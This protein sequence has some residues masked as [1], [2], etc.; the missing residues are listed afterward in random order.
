MVNE[1]ALTAITRIDLSHN[2]LSVL[3]KE[4]FKLVSLKYLNIAQN[5]IAS[6]PF[7][8]QSPN[9]AKYEYNCP[10]LEELFMQ[11][12]RLVMIPADI[13]YL[14]SL[15]ILDISNNKLQELPFDMWKAPKLRE[16]NI[17]F[18]LLKDLP[19]LPMQSST[20]HI[21][22]EKLELEPFSNIESSEACNS[23][24][25]NLNFHQLIHRNVWANSLDITDND[26]KW[27][28]PKKEE[29]VSKLNSLNIANNLFTSIPVVL[30]CLAVNLTRLNMS[31]NSLRSMGHVT[32]YPSAL[33]QLDLSHNEISCWPSLPRIS[34][35]L[36]PHLLCYGLDRSTNTTD[37]TST[38]SKPVGS[39]KT[40]SFRSTV[41]KSVCRHRR[42]LRLESLRTLILADN[43]L[44]RIQL[45]TDDA[46]TLFNES[47]DAD[48][49]VVGVTKSKIIFPNL[50]MLDISNNC[51][52]EIPTSLHELSGLSVLNI[53][54]NVNITDL[55][56]H[57]GLL[58]RLWNLNTRGCML[59]EP[60]KSMIESK[61]YKTMDIIGYLKSIYEN[62]VIYARMKLMVVGVQ[63]IGKTTLLDLLRQGGG[64]QKSRASENH[65]ARRMGHAR[66]TP[67][68]N[69]AGNISTVGVDIGTWICEKRKKSPGSHGPV[70]FRTWDFGGQKE[71]Y[72]TH[73]YFL[74]KRS[75][76]LVLWKITDGHKGLT[77]ILQWLGN[78]Q[79]RAPN[80]AV[81]IV[82]THYDAV[83]DTITA[84]QA[85]EL[86]QIIREKFIAIPDAEKVGLPRVIDSIEIS[87]R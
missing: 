24:P 33:K 15:T 6:L 42:H 14:P 27:N 74:S 30:P 85:E 51:L 39:G 66:N 83:G 12:N 70:I 2:N 61:K 19:V 21:S 17:A 84:Q 28:K 69:C 47:E 67:K 57:L 86:Q 8:A 56:P 73:Q 49:S 41:L 68:S 10:V 16:L 60:L 65:W 20:A 72:A 79:A 3:P 9:S 78:I 46:T 45:S 43:L 82:G 11:D 48:W 13:F 5:K 52:K 1:V 62:S 54:G 38:Y 26:M 36:D 71:Y 87:C 77:E 50:S 37:D 31:Y 44:T 63:G 22:L 55:P 81:I 7:P 53:S 32:G 76:Y 18:N 59:Q 34:G 64:S 23:K 29:G 75:L 40:I 4:I 25:R 58:S 35:D 80:S